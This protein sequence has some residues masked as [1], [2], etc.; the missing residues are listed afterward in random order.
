MKYIMYL[1]MISSLFCCCKVA[2]ELLLNK[3]PYLGNIETKGCFFREIEEEF[4]EVF[5]IYNDG[6]FL[7]GGVMRLND[8]ENNL[9]DAVNSFVELGYFKNTQ[10]GWGVW[11]EEGDQII[12]E[13][14][15]SG[16]GGPYPVGRYVGDIINDTTINIAFTYQLPPEGDEEK[17]IFKFREFSPKPDSTNT[18]IK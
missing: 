17:Q 2:E 10:Y 9:D 15:L 8:I 5:F 14:W 7:S 1:F 11:K 3:T 18:F 12:I 16:S 13:K 6:V 4:Y